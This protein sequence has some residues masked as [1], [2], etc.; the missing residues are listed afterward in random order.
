MKLLP[1]DLLKELKHYTQKIVYNI[2]QIK[3]YVSHHNAIRAYLTLL[4]GKYK[5]SEFNKCLFQY[6]DNTKQW[7]FTKP[8][9]DTIFC[10]WEHII[11]VT[12]S[13][14]YAGWGEEP[15]GKTYCL[16][17]GKICRYESCNNH[18]I[19]GMNILTEDCNHTIK[20]G[21]RGYWEYDP[22][23]NLLWRNEQY[24]DTYYRFY[25]NDVLDSTMDRADST[26]DSSQLSM[27]FSS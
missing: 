14:D 8:P 2:C 20:N 18:C 26:N 6:D 13:D 19:N 7:T 12:L 10:R 4:G 27:A 5:G 16:V 15:E 23:G 22:T 17:N 21:D 24:P 11:E 3:R 25:L 1:C 9:P